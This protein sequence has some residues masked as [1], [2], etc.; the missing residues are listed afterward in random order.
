M[1]CIG[2]ITPEYRERMYDILDLY[3]EKYD[4]KN[5]VVCMDEKSKQLLSDTRI[6]IDMKP[7]KCK[8]IDYEYKRG[9]TSNIFVAVEP[10]GGKRKTEVTKRRTRVDFAYFVKNLV[11]KSYPRATKIRLVLDNLNTHFKKSFFET[12]KR[13]E[14]RRILKRIE[15]HYT[16]KHASWLNMAEIEIGVLESQCLK[17]RI[18]NMETMKKEVAAWEKRRNNQK[19]KLKWT[20]TREAADL[21]LSKYY[22]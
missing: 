17:K 8:K 14:A 2:K 13:S 9:G 3:A 22:I 19:A 4:R 11:D 21:K 20:F 15:F 10:K 16:P 6:S 1:W 12:F 7:G 18:G 5:P